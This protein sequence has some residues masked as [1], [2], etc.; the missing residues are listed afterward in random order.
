MA[1]GAS[2]RYPLTKSTAMSMRGLSVEGDRFLPNS[3]YAASKAGGELMLRAYQVTYGMDT[4]VTRGSNTYGPYQY[5]E[6]LIP[7]FTT[8]ALG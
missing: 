5:P 2:V 8:E 6:K 3:P 4:V 1:S 7:F